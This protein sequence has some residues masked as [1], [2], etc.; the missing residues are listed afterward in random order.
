MKKLAVLSIAL[1]V[2]ATLAFAEVKVEPVVA[3]SGSG[4]LTWGI[5][6]DS[7]PINTGFKNESSANLTVTLVS[8][9]TETKGMMAEGEMVYGY[10]ALKDMQLVINT[11]NNFTSG[12]DDEAK[13]VA[14]P[15]GTDSDADGEVDQYLIFED[16]DNTVKI[17][18]DIITPPSIEA[19]VVLGPAKWFIYAA[20][21]LK[22][23]YADDL[24][25]DAD[26]DYWAEVGDDGDDVAPNPDGDAGAT[27]IEIAAGPATITALVASTKD[28]TAPGTYSIAA[29]AALV[30]GPATVKAGLNYDLATGGVLGLGASAAVAAG[31]ISVNAAFDMTTATGT[32]ME[33]RAGAKL[34]LPDLLDVTADMAYGAG[35]AT[36]WGFDVEAGATLKAV[37]GLDFS[38]L[39]GLWNLTDTMSW[40]LKTVAGYKVAMGETN[41]VKPGVEAYVSSLA[42]AG[43]RIA[44]IAKIEAVLIPNTTFTLQYKD[45]DLTDSDTFTGL[46]RELTFATKVAY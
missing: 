2:L 42:G 45:K 9:T 31:P 15:A 28:W 14:V 35:S 34:A 23:S 18:T 24:E 12:D 36:P 40:G 22:L 4:T 6:L 30:V 11:D 33:I 44:L 20:P 43:A 17:P 41:Y 37:A 32:P 26:D 21:D 39:F 27:G 38:A 7:D 8:K 25:D 16:N 19:Y 46:S 29:K 5:D 1:L 13:L 3:F 10:I